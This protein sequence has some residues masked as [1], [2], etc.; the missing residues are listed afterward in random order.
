MY[1]RVDMTR[2]LRQ[3]RRQPWRNPAQFVCLDQNSWLKLPSRSHFHARRHLHRR[4]PFLVGNW[5]QT[6]MNKIRG[7]A[8]ARTHMQMSRCNY[9]ILGGKR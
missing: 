3:C 9:S 7:N 8:H 4:Q 1:C 5:K 6:Q 2:V